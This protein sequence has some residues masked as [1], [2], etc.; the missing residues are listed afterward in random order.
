MIY[1]NCIIN[2]NC[3]EIMQG[4]PEK[5]IDLVMFSPPYWG[6]RDYGEATELV[7]GGD[8]NCE[9]EWGYSLKA[10]GRV[11]EAW[12]TKS[13]KINYLNF[14]NGK[15]K[16]NFCVLCGAWRG[17]FGLE[18]TPEFYVKHLAEICQAV[19]RV[20]KNRGSFY[21]NIDDTYAGSHCAR[22]YKTP[23]Q[24][25]RRMYI[26]DMIYNKPSPQSKIKNI[27]RKSLVGIPWR[28]ALHLI[29]NQGWILRNDIIWHKPN[30]MPESVKDRLTRSYEH[31]F[32]FVK[33]PK[34]YYN[35]DEI[36]V[37][38]KAGVTRWGGQTMRV[39]KKE[40]KKQGL[41]K[42]LLNKD[43]PWRN[44]K[45]KNPGD[46]LKLNSIAHPSG[47]QRWEREG[48]N[49]VEARFN[50][51]DKK[52]GDYW[53]I[54]TKPYREAHFAVYPEAICEQPI[55]SSCPPN[56]IVLDP[57][58]GSGTTCVVAHKLGHQWIGIELNPEY[59]EIARNRISKLSE[60]RGMWF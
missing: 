34:Y 22:G 32:H 44:P 8:V 1:S 26:A 50:L 6:K 52:P 45:G 57:L 46:M 41:A 19:K 16:S 15:T 49:R 35:L 59:A 53:A 14:Q 7:W 20:L 28:V 58:C 9:H 30:H 47:G 23:F 31:I 42:A 51:K 55:K 36:R 25:Y 18:P 56:G 11:G 60:K 43:R 24:N 39:P 17:Q 48:T 29:D 54:N 33:Q 12:N 3:L 21:L 10:G 4:F 13:K 27:Q 38:H 37:A 40:K 2:G 5:S